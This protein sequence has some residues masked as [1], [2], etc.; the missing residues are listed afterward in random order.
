MGSS[1]TATLVNV[2]GFVTG[3]ALY[4]TLLAMVW[5]TQKGLPALKPK[6]VSLKTREADWLL[7]TTALLGL[8]WNVGAL[9]AILI[10]GFKL[11]E[12]QM[13]AALTYSS[14]GLL[15]AVVVHSV[16]RSSDQLR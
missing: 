9:I 8:T 5:P 12:P 3:A 11:G 4:A 13:L 2:V 15:P 6:L 16:L 7:I 14:L 1:D 10:K